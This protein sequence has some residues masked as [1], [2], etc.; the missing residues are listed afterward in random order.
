MQDLAG[1]DWTSP[2][3]QASTKPITISSSNYYSTLRPT[4]P[5]SGRSTPLASGATAALSKSGVSS[6]IPS[7]SSTPANESFANLVSF[8]AVQSKN[9]TLQERQ[10]ELEEQREKHNVD[11]RRQL[12]SQLGSRDVEY[13]N[14][15]GS[16]RATPDTITSPPSYTGTDEY[17]G[18][19][20]STAINKPFAVIGTTNPS[21]PSRK[22]SKSEDDLLAAFSANAPVDK[23]S[24]FPVPVRS[25]DDSTAR[26][27]PSRPTPTRQ[28]GADIDNDPFGLGEMGPVKAAQPPQSQ[29]EI[30]DDDVLGLL[31]RPVSDFSTPQAHSYIITSPIT[32]N[33][34]DKAIAELIDM[35]FPAD[36]SKTALETT[37]S[38][39]DVQSAVGWLLNEAHRE[40]K[41]QPRI[42][43]P[44]RRNS[45]ESMNRQ[46]CRRASPTNGSDENAP[47]PTWMR[48]QSRSNSTQRRQDNRSPANLD[49][50]SAKYATELGNN[51]FKTANSLWKTG[52]K[53]I[54]QAVSEF[55]SSEG[56]LNQPKWMR[57]AHILRQSR[58]E[59]PPLHP[60]NGPEDKSLDSQPKRAVEQSSAQS[61]ITD[62]AMMLES[63]DANSRSR[64]RA[65][66]PAHAPIASS[67]AG[68][69]PSESQPYVPQ[70]RVML[71]E[72]VQHHPIHQP[73]E[74]PRSKVSRMAV[75]EQSSQ[76]YQSPARR[77]KPTPKPPSPEPNLLHNIFGLPNSSQKS[78]LVP[79]ARTSLPTTLHSRPSPSIREV[80]PISSIA[81]QS[82]TSHRNAGTAAF[83]L[84]NYAEANASYTSSLSS[85][86][87]E[88]PLVILLLTNRAL[89][90]LKT[91]DPKS[92]IADADKALMVIGSSK[93]QGE[94][95][96]VGHGEGNKDMSSFW[97]KAMTRKAEALE[98]LERW[99]DAAKVWRECVEAGVGGSTSVQGRNRC[100]RAMD[101]GP[102][103]NMNVVKKPSVAARKVQ[104]KP[105]S[106]LDDL[107]GRSAVNALQSGEAVNRLR[108]ANTK[109]EQVDD[110]KFAL[111]DRVD[112]RLS[113]WQ[114]GKEGNLRALLG[115]LDTVL[116]EGSGWKK[117][118]MSELI[119]PGKV[120]VAYMK[121][122]SKVHP[123]K[124]CY[125]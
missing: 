115:S 3:S 100:E 65:Q 52:T 36:R 29:P 116:W 73:K 113:N 26:P 109:A 19:K 48:Q 40:S 42:Q 32:S 18:Q 8:N 43:P 108:A 93:G 75:E 35:G 63:G 61:N 4:P 102:A 119:L 90:H 50:D 69:R 14:Q 55:N 72:P 95:V 74:Q 11:R 92:C 68:Y 106:A 59:S 5:I 86:P 53:K 103:K 83:K 105:V 28:Q 122:I 80:P 47:I 101:H 66:K 44:E 2:V 41:Q 45:G 49:K 64:Q 87:P 81:L 46:S 31:G 78:T 54:N 84:G 30:E 34:V 125:L 56:D 37:G 85:V 24:N 99:N 71:T 94:S 21:L 16:G 67:D 57:E 12:G 112:G 88:H 98:Q 25:R 89:T 107:S 91:G 27:E 20:L 33:L 104:P 114:K 38:G 110:E 118:G 120:K 124:V 22:L 117:V 76:A 79:Q 51:I 13:L 96:E 97:G 121:G 1:L 6:P 70:R 123:D 60:N 58:T 17:G 7:K 23:S 9:L 62:E 39:V 77:K 10:K 111:A 82:S 15:L